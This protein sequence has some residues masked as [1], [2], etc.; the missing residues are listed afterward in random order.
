[1]QWGQLDLMTA[2]HQRELLITADQERLHRQ[3]SSRARRSMG[4]RRHV[5]TVGRTLEALGR[6]LESAAAHPGDQDAA[7]PSGA[8]V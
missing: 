4:W 8:F 3:A 6:R 2:E 7:P 5:W 1:M